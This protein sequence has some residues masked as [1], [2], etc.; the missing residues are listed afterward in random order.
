MEQIVLDKIAGADLLGEFAKLGESLN[1]I[2]KELQKSNGNAQAAEYITRKE[3]AKML[4]VTLA[5]LSRWDKM[6]FLRAHRIGARVYYVR[7]KKKS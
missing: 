2:K 3:T 6:G 1:E 5:T 4:H 7:I